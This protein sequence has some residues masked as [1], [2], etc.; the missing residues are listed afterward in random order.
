[1]RKYVYENAIVYITEPT[2]EQLENIKKATER[3]V[4]RLA[5]EGLIGND[6]RRNNNRIGRTG[7]NARK[8]N[9]QTEKED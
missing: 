1:M 2:E 5:K 3:F 4:H 9:R 6:K 7:S 8:R